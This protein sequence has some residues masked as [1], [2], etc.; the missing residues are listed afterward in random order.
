M[1]DRAQRF[2]S[3]LIDALGFGSRGVF[4]LKQSGAFLPGAEALGDVFD[5]RDEVKRCVFPVAD[6]RETLIS[7]QIS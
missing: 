7:T 5:L 1:R 3:R 4:E 6:E 2:V